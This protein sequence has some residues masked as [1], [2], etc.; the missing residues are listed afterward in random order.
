MPDL[1]KSPE[2][3]CPACGAPQAVMVD[4]APSK[5]AYQQDGP[6]VLYLLCTNC[7]QVEVVEEGQHQGDSSQFL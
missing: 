6:H 5:D 2:R 4:F 3:I 7:S 1:E